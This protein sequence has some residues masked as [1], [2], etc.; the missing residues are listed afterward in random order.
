MDGEDPFVAGEA[1]HPPKST[2]ILTDDGTIPGRVVFGQT[3]PT[4]DFAEEP[5][6]EAPEHGERDQKTNDDPGYSP[7][8]EIGSVLVHSEMI[9]GARSEINS[10]AGKAA[11]RILDT[12]CNR[13]H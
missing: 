4:A 5:P 10:Q 8:G 9:V 12:I 1:D 7:S 11:D 13:M 6:D 3:R 2:V